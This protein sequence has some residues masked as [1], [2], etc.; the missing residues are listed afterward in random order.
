M[1]LKKYHLKHNIGD[2]IWFYNGGLFVTRGLI[3]GVSINIVKCKDGSLS[4]EDTY[5]LSFYSK[6]TRKRE[7]LYEVHQDAISKNKKDMVNL[8]YKFNMGNLK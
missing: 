7:M 5:H 2:K 1:E 4:R 3:E 8:M 6:L